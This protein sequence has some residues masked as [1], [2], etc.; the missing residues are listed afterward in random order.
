MSTP[1][2]FLHIAGIALVLS[3]LI[4][5][6]I[7]AFSHRWV[8]RSYVESRAQVEAI[9]FELGGQ[10]SWSQDPQY[11]K[12]VSNEN[13]RRAWVVGLTVVLGMLAAY[14]AQDVAHWVLFTSV[15]WLVALACVVDFEHCLIPDRASLGLLA[16][17]LVFACTQWAMITP[18]QAV[19]GMLVGYAALY[20]LS[21]VFVR[22]RG[23]E[24]VGE[25][26]LKLLAAAG[27][28][29]GP[30]GVAYVAGFAVLF[31]LLSLP[32]LMRQGEDEIRVPFGPGLALGLFALLLWQSSQGAV[33]LG[34]L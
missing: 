19:L 13:R 3:A 22:L 11:A 7:S 12:P 17:G 14:A 8:E 33:W 23:K 16:L 15:A 20:G 18:E 9:A 6:W 32:W 27:T 34:L 29:V 2:E 1:L 30:W 28:F 10:V 4:G 21:E 24:P 31:T 26:D 5:L 25:A